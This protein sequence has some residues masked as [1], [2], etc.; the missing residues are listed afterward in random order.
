MPVYEVCE[1]AA[2][3][4]TVDEFRRAVVWGYDPKGVVECRA[5]DAYYPLQQQYTARLDTA[6]AKG[7]TERD[8]W[9]YWTTQAA[10]GYFTMRTVP[11]KVSAKSLN[12][13]INSVL[14][15][16]REA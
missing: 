5:L 4:P 7:F 8:L 11:R 1:E 15:A 16:W 12:E 9:A 3:D 2:F 10:S 6:R 14:E 13:A